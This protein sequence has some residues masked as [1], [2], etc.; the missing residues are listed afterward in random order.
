MLKREP[1][2]TSCC[3]V[4]CW[5][6]AARE[7]PFWPCDG[8]ELAGETAADESCWRKSAPPLVVP[9]LSALE[10]LG[11]A[12]VVFVALVLPMLSALE[13]LG[14]ALI[15]F[16]VSTAFI[17][18]TE[19]V[20][21][22]PPVEFAVLVED[23]DGFNGTGAGAGTSTSAGATLFGD[24]G[25]IVAT[26]APLS[27]VGSDASS[28]GVTENRFSGAGRGVA[29]TARETVPVLSR[30]LGESNCIRSSVPAEAESVEGGADVESAT[31]T[32]TDGL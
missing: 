12:L 14:I 7:A 17:P 19:V 3:G 32:T 25:A 27:P 1:D 2:F 10:C 21:L 28:S 6:G 9:M 31:S 23:E 13:C 15:A 30:S 29:A 16:V 5:D 22:S 20:A 4:G 11:I 18:L 26:A 8:G 24:T